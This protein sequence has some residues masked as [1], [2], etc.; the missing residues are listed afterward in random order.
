M[1]E[2]MSAEAH[3]RDASAKPKPARATIDP[4]AAAQIEQML[5]GLALLM[6]RSAAHRTMTVADLEAFVLPPL[7][8]RQAKIMKA[9][10]GLVGYVSWAFVSP[11]VEAQLSG[12]W[13]RLSGSD[14]RSGEQAWIVDLVGPPKVANALLDT[15]RRGPLADRS[16]KIRKGAAGSEV[17]TL[18]PISAPAAAV[19]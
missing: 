9:K 2:V 6:T 11:E 19:Q 18:D 3:A 14:W 16:V 8:L 13:P 7:V 5:G 4:A 10:N 17:L 15:V 12:R 1:T